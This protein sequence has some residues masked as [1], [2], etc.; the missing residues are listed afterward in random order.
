M[1]SERIFYPIEI[2]RRELEGVFLVAAKLASMGHKVFLGPKYELDY[3]LKRYKPNIYIGTRA[4]ETNY[5]LLKTLRKSGCKVVIVDTEGGIM[6]EDQY[7]T[8]HYAPGLTQ[9]DL[10]FAWGEKGASIIRDMDVISPEQIK[11]SGAPWFDINEVK[12]LYQDLVRKLKEEFPRSYILFNSRLSLPNHKSKIISDNYRAQ[13]PEEFDYYAKQYY[14]LND[15]IKRLAADF[16]DETFVIRAHPSEDPSHYYDFFK[17]LSNVVINDS[18]S[19][20]A[21]ALASKVVLHNSC[22]TGLEAAMMGVPVI[23]YQEVKDDQYDKLLPNIA[24]MNAF[25][26]EQLVQKVSYY[27][28]HPA[29]PYTL[30]RDQIAAIKE[31]FFNVDTSGSDIIVKHVSELNSGEFMYKMD[32]EYK[33]TKFKM[34]I[35]YK[36]PFLI[37]FLPSELKKNVRVGKK[38]FMGKF[39]SLELDQLLALRQRLKEAN[40][41]IGKFTIQKCPDLKQAYKFEAE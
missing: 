4:D 11:V 34:D 24:S 5:G 21:W 36:Y 17:G 32:P 29:E 39:Q 38:Y 26:Y 27:I 15:T 22:T 10:F 14:N 28:Q 7:K 23:A 9:A 20:R 41:N 2:T 33:K 8:R 37:N 16:P 12:P 31:F 6:L 13:A 19:A 30:N 40:P 1:K 18:Y 35:I 3:C 25:T